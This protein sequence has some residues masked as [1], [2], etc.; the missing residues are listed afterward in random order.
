MTLTQLQSNMT[1]A[2][3]SIWMAYFSLMNDKQEAT[4]KKARSSRR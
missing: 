2:E 4:M 1:Y 3:L